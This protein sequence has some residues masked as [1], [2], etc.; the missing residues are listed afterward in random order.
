MESPEEA[1]GTKGFDD[2]SGTAVSPV[3]TL[4]S[5]VVPVGVCCSG[6]RLPVGV[7]A[8]ADD[9]DRNVPEVEYGDIRIESTVTSWPTAEAATGH[10]LGHGRVPAV[11]DLAVDGEHH[12]RGAPVDP[13]AVR[14]PMKLPA[15]GWSIALEP[16]VVRASGRPRSS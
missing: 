4:M 3:R 7:S 10:V 8:D 16:S 15:M 11:D 13:A 5:T 1:T 6:H 9:R 12:L 14:R 2:P